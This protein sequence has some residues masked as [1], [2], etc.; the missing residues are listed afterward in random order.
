MTKRFQAR[1]GDVF[2]EAATIPAGAQPEE[3]KSDRVVLAY[4]E[5]TGHAHAF[6][7]SRVCFFR[8]TGSDGVRTFIRVSGDTPVPLQHEEHGAIEVPPGE[9]EVR[10]QS[11]YSPDEIR[12]VCD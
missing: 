10:I 3:K 6:Y 9:Y 12:Q 2:I 5:V 4:G 7:S 11:E 1:Q 8:E